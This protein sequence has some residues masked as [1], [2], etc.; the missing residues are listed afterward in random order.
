MTRYWPLLL[1]AAG[2]LLLVT[3]FVY[4]VIFAGIPYQDPTPDMSARYARHA[5]I[6]AAIRWCGV[7]AVLLG[8]TVGLV[9][10]GSRTPER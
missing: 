5:V 7:G 6:A 3:G 2:L 9:R 1:A 10:R 4:D 8:L